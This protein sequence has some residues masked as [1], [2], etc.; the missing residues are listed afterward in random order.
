MGDVSELY[1][2]GNANDQLLVVMLTAIHKKG[3]RDFNDENL[4]NMLKQEVIKDKKAA[5]I[6]EKVQAAKSVAEVAKMSGAVQDTVSHITFASPVFVQKV[7]SQEPILSGA[8][9]AAKK[10]QFVSGIR[11]EG[12]V[13]AFQVLEKKALEGKFDQK[14]E[15]TQQAATLSRSVNGMMQVLARKA[16]IE[17]NRYKFYQ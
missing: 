1:E 2:A 16:K 5:Q 4:Q 10:D 6:L 12:A 3:A 13:Y 15:E 8:A 11:G 14:Q 17:D 7:A 9:A